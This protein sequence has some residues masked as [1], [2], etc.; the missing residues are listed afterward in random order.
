MYLIYSFSVSPCVG[1]ARKVV[2][3]MNLLSKVVAAD[4]ESV[5]PVSQT[6][7]SYVDHHRERLVT[8]N[9]L[10]TTLAGLCA[11]LSAIF[12]TMI[13]LGPLWRYSWLILCLGTTVLMFVGIFGMGF[14]IGRQE[15]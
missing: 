12:A 13:E 11:F 7:Q 2:F 14:A 4:A 9:L 15:D 3:K 5:V 1:S 10:L 6:H 8:K